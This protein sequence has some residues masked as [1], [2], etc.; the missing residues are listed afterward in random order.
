MCRRGL[1][2]LTLGA[3]IA[4]VVFAAVVVPR[5]GSSASGFR[6]VVIIL[7]ANFEVP[8]SAPLCPAGG[9]AC[10]GAPPPAPMQCYATESHQPL[11]SVGRRT[12]GS[13]FEWQAMT[14]R[15]IRSAG[16]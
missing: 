3:V 10:M 1:Q 12:G 4:I 2:V 7:F 5:L 13:S 14:W 9:Q 8:L 16:P 11:S 15:E 6:N